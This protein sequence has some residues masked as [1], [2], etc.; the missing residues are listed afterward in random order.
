MINS[1]LTTCDDDI[2]YFLYT[3]KF[4]SLLINVFFINLEI[5]ILLID[6]IIILL[7]RDDENKI[8][9]KELENFNI[10]EIL[11]KICFE[12]KINVVE[13]TIKNILENYF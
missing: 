1:L 5:N 13:E 2:I 11:N 8:Y 3:K 9:K 6:L 4:I 10:K 12:C 7:R